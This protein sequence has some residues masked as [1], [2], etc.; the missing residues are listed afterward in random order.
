MFVVSAWRTF[1]VCVPSVKSCPWRER[2]PYYDHTRNLTSPDSLNRRR[3]LAP[4]NTSCASAWKRRVSDSLTPRRTPPK[5]RWNVASGKPAVR[6]FRGDD[7]NV[8]NHRR[9]VRAIVLPDHPKRRWRGRL[10]QLSLFFNDAIL[11]VENI[12]NVP[13]HTY[14]ASFVPGSDATKK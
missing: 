2:R 3:A 9:P 14:R 10:R 6:N 4:P 8:G 1:A 12:G 5:S 13:G 7:G 11:Q